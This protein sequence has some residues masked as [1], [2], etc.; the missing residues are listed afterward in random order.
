VQSGVPWG[1]LLRRAVSRD[2]EVPWCPPAFS[3]SVCLRHRSVVPVPRRRHTLRA[4]T[5]GGERAVVV[6]FFGLGA[7][8]GYRGG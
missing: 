4:W 5:M 7:G 8:A 1:L 6:M 3:R 2:P